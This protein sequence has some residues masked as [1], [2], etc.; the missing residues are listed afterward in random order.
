MKRLLAIAL[1]TSLVLNA[2]CA[3]LLFAPGEGPAVAP[4]RI[5][6]RAATPPPLTPQ[7]W[8]SL[9]TGDLPA[10][11]ARLRAAGFPPDIVEAVVGTKVRELFAARRRALLSSVRTAPFWMLPPRDAQAQLALNDLLLEQQ[12]VMARLLA[13]YSGPAPRDPRFAFLPGD[14]AEA[15]ARV[16]REHNDQRSRLWTV[17]Y[18]DSNERGKF[19]QIEQ[20]RRAALA[21]LL[22]VEE[23]NE[24]NVRM[25]RTA[26]GLRDRLAVFEPTEVEFRTIHSLQAAFDDQWGENFDITQTEDNQQRR[27]EAEKRL[28][29]A[30]KAALGPERAAQYERATDWNYINTSRLVERLALPRETADRLHAMQQEFERRRDEVVRSAPAAERLPQLTR[31][32]KEA[33]DRVTPLFGGK[34]GNVEVY[35]NHG[36]DWMKYLLPHPPRRN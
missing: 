25:S 10:L 32:Q 12:Q 7:I 3:W 34:P 36:G 1:V 5:A 26:E 8:R 13:G 20:Q 9:E 31:L 14:K 18:S 2:V 15:V 17:G 21:Q 16:I 33:I 19:E 24:Y 35:Q 28:A 23:L 4:P 6:D 22:T 11:I 27:R 30:I 29:D